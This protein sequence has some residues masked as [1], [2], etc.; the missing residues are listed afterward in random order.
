MF[1][2]EKTSSQRMC[3]KHER[4]GTFVCLHLRHPVKDA[5]KYKTAFPAK[6]TM[7]KFQ[8]HALVIV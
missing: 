3:V 1:K 2:A 7:E 5:S 4:C 8:D 6:S